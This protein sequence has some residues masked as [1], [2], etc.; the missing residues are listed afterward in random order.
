MYLDAVGPD[1]VGTA[2]SEPARA[3]TVAAT[4][5][6]PQDAPGSWSRTGGRPRAILLVSDGEN[7][8][9]GEQADGSAA[10]ADELRGAGVELLA[11]AVGTEEG[12]TIPLPNDRVQRDR[13]G[14][15]IRT[16]LDMVALTSIA[17]RDVYRA[18][19]DPLPALGERLD[20]LAGGGG[21]LERVPAAAERF[22]WPLGAALLLLVADRLVAAWAGR[23]ARTRG[24][25][26]ASVDAPTSAVPV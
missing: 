19:A 15:V 12:G 18:D 11:L 2:G 24:R 21:S 20:E 4:A 6:E 16:R 5:L 23:R 3:L 8:N 10:L 25:Q 1:I 13:E 26:G 14:D 7:P 22:Q 17:G 9:A